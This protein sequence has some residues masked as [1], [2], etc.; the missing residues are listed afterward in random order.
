MSNTY[1]KWAKEQH[2]KTKRLAKTKSTSTPNKAL[3]GKRT[4][5]QR[6]NTEQLLKSWLQTHQK[7]KN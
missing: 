1:K 3:I 4:K 2:N 7:N 6:E 5:E